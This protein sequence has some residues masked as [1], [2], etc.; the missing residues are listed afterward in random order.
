M[1][2][3]V[4]LADCHPHQ[5]VQFIYSLAIMLSVPL[6]LFSAVR[7]MENGIFTRSDKGNWSVKWAKNWFRFATVAASALLSWRGAADLVDFV[8]FVGCFVWY[9]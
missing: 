3:Q 8:A 7:I 9:V 6:Q 1:S 4:L 2:S 5:Q